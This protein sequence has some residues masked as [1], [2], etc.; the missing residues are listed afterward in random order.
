MKTEEIDY[1]KILKLYCEK[2]TKNDSR[3]MD[4]TEPHH[5]QLGDLTYTFACTHKSLAYIKRKIEITEEHLLNDIWNGKI[6]DLI[7]STE[8]EGSKIEVSFE[9]MKKLYDEGVMQH[10]ERKNKRDDILFVLSEYYLS[11][12]NLEKIYKTMKYLKSKR[13]FVQVV[14]SPFAGRSPFLKWIFTNKF[15]VII[16][17]ITYVFCV[18]SSQVYGTPTMPNAIKFE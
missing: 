3:D 15:E 17:V 10:K 9:K 16:E 7:V 12:E 6:L 4:F 1:N 5:L 8:P 2:P 13:V 11:L 18:G 14:R